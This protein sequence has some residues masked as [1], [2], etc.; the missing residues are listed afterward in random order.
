VASAH[1][2]T[3]AGS[4]AAGHLDLAARHLSG[5]LIQAQTA[6]SHGLH[7]LL[8]TAALTAIAGAAAAFRYVRVGTP[9]LRQHRAGGAHRLRCPLTATRTGSHVIT[10]AGTRSRP[11]G[12]RPATPSNPQ[13]NSRSVTGLKQSAEAQQQ[14]HRTSRRR[15]CSLGRATHGE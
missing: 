10:A 2:H 15:A 4:V 9:P 8:A 5:G 6:F 11:A 3:A 1:G 7:L 13:K 14:Q 12:S